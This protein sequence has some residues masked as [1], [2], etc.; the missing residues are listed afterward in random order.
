METRLPTARG[1]FPAL[2]EGP[3]DAPVVLLLH[4]F[5]DIPY[6]YREIQKRLTDHGLRSVAPYLR[7]YSPAPMEGPYDI[8]S[9]AA[10]IEAIARYL[11]P[12]EPITLVG[13]DW[14]AACSYVAAALYPWRFNALVTLS[15]PHPVTF[16]TALLSNPEQILKSWYIFLFQPRGVAEFALRRKNFELIDQ[17]WRTWSP[18][19]ELHPE[20]LPKLKRCLAQSLPAPLEYYRAMARP[21][22]PALRRLRGP[23]AR[24]IQVPT[25]HLTGSMDQCVSVSSGAGQERYFDGYFRSELIDGAGHFLPIERPEIVAHR[26]IEHRAAALSK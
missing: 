5:P 25:L 8:E 23:A 17:L 20:Y 14:G 24:R 11:S 18:G 15:V 16:F 26:I 3:E 4:G 19:I 21:V 22:V 6:T 7:G 13:H 9:I 1:V 2:I 12:N 10:D